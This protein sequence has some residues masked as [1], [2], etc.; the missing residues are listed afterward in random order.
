MFASIL[1]WL[2]QSWFGQV[3]SFALSWWNSHEQA[4]TDQSNAVNTALGQHDQDGATSVADTV[5][6]DAQNA[7]LDAAEK[8][9]DNPTPVV[10]TTGSK[11]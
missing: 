8:Q 9:L 11:P 5:S 1:A 3:V 7:A 6:S 2:T 4:I 10:V